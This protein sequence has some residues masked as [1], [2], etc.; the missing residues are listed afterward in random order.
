M[1]EKLKEKSVK[2]ALLLQSELYRLQ[3]DVASIKKGIEDNKEVEVGEKEN[4]FKK[5]G[6]SIGNSVKKSRTE[7]FEKALAKDQAKNTEIN[8]DGLII[9]EE[10]F[11]ADAKELLNTQ[12]KKVSFALYYLSNDAFEYESKEETLQGLS[13]ALFGNKEALATLAKELDGNFKAV[14]VSLFSGMKYTDEAK[15]AIGKYF[16]LLSNSSE[17]ECALCQA[18]G[19]MNGN[20]DAIACLLAL[21]LCGNKDLPYCNDEEKGKDAFLS[22][23]KESFQAALALKATLFQ[24]E[25]KEWSEDEKKANVKGALSSF[26]TLSYWA[27]VAYLLEGKDKDSCKEKIK[28]LESYVTLLEELM[29]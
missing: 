7:S 19:A 22:I 12:A 8:P 15:A 5:F 3:L 26:A 2:E 24:E 10:E 9:D 6:K 20:G 18:K 4:V 16:E 28:G 29:K 25:K 21:L 11:K 23:S 17:G 1:N 27:K 13:E 14:T